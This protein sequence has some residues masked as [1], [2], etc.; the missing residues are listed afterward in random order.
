MLFSTCLNTGNDTRSQH[1]KEMAT[2]CCAVAAAVGV[3]PDASES[4]APGS[5]S[6]AASCKLAAPPHSAL[7][8]GGSSCLQPWSLA[9]RRFSSHGH[10]SHALEPSCLQSVCSCPFLNVL[11][12]LFLRLILSV[13]PPGSNP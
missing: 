12:V 7:N 9:G 5:G 11:S 6:R 13:C 10:V 3:S 4:G 8:P 1:R 2:V